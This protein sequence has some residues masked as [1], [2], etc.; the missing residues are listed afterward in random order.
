MMTVGRVWCCRS[1]ASVDLLGLGVVAIGS[2]GVGDLTAVHSSLAAF[3]EVVGLAYPAN[4]GTV[5]RWARQLYR[6]VH[7][8]MDGDLVLFRPSVEG[9]IHVGIL[10]GAYEYAGEACCSH[11]RP[12]RWTR[13]GMSA[14]DL[15]A[16]AV[17]EMWWPVPEPSLNL[18]ACPALP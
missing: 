18:V 7:E 17:D 1:S 16:A 8:A 15:P 10:A 5:A 14:A 4:P 9:L 3:R 12:V 13:P 11:R 2:D 6:F